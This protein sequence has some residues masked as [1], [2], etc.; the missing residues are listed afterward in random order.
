M[1]LCRWICTLRLYSER[2]SEWVPS[3]VQSR[4]GERVLSG[5][6]AAP[7]SVAGLVAWARFASAHSLDAFVLPWQPELFG[8]APHFSDDPWT[9]LQLPTWHP[10]S[11]DPPGIRSAPPLG[12]VPQPPVQCHAESHSLHASS[13]MRSK[14]SSEPLLAPRLVPPLGTPLGTR[15]APRL[16]PRLAPRLEPAQYPAWDPLSTPLVPHSAST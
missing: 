9:S 3:G 10:P 12:T 11:S 7:E 2:V 15:L 13:A 5:V 6:Q 1:L 4:A 16:V 14:P 8:S